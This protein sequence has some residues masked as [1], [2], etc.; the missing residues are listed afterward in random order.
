L[1]AAHDENNGVLGKIYRYNLRVDPNGKRRRI[2]GKKAMR[3]CV[4]LAINKR[5][6]GNLS[7]IKSNL[8]SPRGN[9]T[10]E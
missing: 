1:R 9:D 7:L 3:K 10:K 8:P 4:W 6:K 2:E 5:V